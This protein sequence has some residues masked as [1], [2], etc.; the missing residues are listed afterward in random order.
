MGGWRDS[1]QTGAVLLAL[2]VL[3]PSASARWVHDVPLFVSAAHPSGHQGFVR[4]ANRSGKAGEVSIVAIDDAGD[5]YGP[6][7]LAIEAHRTR[8]FNSADL[9]EGNEAKGLPDGVGEGEG[10]WRLQLQSDLVLEV[11]AYNRTADGLLTPLHDVVPLSDEGYVVVIFNPGSNENQA[12]RLR[13]VNPGEEAVE[14]RIEGTDDAGDA[15]QSAVTLTVPGGAARTL[16][17]RALESG[18]GDGLS[19]ALGD[20]KG[21][22]RLVVTADRLVTVMNLMVTP[23]AHL[24]NLSRPGAAGKVGLFSCEREASRFRT[25]TYGTPSPG[26]CPWL[27]A[28]PSRWRGC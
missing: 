21:K 11:G 3:P 22:W 25:Q 6:V 9:E 2:T 24:V 16:P 12:S 15:G 7:T 4:V 26:H 23:T 5:E 14:V 20:G 17:A 18:Q 27:G 13:I 10:N 1:L 8:H 19:G 28:S